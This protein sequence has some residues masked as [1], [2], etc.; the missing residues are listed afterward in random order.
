VDASTATR[1]VA[2]MERA[3]LITRGR[4]PQDTA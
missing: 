3:G 4:D 2:A 1:Q